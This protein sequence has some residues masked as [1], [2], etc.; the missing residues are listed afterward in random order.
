[1]SKWLLEVFPPPH[2]QIVPLHL[3]QYMMCHLIMMT[4]TFITVS[5]VT[6]FFLTLNKSR[7]TE[8]CQFQLLHSLWLICAEMDTV[9]N[10]LLPNCS[11][12][13]TKL[14]GNIPHE[15]CRL[16]KNKCPIFPTHP[17]VMHGLFMPFPYRHN[18]QSQNIYQ[19]QNGGL[20]GGPVLYLKQSCC[21]LS[22]DSASCNL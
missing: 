5:L 11:F 15:F 6:F 20:L 1:V 3:Y 7:T 8:F 14:L 16:H 22:A 9:F 19:P 21:T 18:H 13:Y 2:L 10:Y 17:S 4:N 12:G